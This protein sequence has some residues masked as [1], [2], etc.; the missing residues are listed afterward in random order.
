MLSRLLR[1][2]P[3]PPTSPAAPPREWLHAVAGRELPLKVV[4]NARA[5]RLTLRIDAGGRSLR[6]TVPPGV[7]ARE[8]ENFLDRHAGWLEDRLA[9]YPDRP[10]L[11][12]GVKVPLYGVP[13]LIVHEPGRR[14]TVEPGEA[15]GVRTLI[16]HG[17][18]AHLKRRLADFMKREARRAIEPLVEAHCATAGRR[19]TAVRYK[20]TVSRWG[21]CTA[22]G[23]LAFSWRI[24]MAPRP[25]ID[26]LVAHEVAHLIHMN[27][28]Q[29]F[30]ALCRQLCP[31]TD[32]ARA[33]LKKN[34]GAL[35]AIGF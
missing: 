5:T 28:G 19:A 11:R 10:E 17:E 25:V 4:E 13:H 32:E 30:W 27:H 26:Y 14:G 18:R 6:V 9:K 33:W 21:S 12:P 34:G 2:R 16:V 8:V 7:A 22:D 20:D 15:D 35:Q 31:R 23:A 3:A 29:K 24:V 1:S